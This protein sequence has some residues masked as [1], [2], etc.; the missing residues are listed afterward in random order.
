MTIRPA[1]ST[2]WQALQ[3]LNDEVITD[4]AQYDDDIVLGWALSDEGKEY[5]Q[6]IVQDPD[7]VCFVAEDEHGQLLGYIDA[8]PK[9]FGYRKSRYLEIGDMGVK[10]EYRSQGIGSMLMKAVQD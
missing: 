8:S 3:K 1:S 2:E 10:P 9:N 6:K 5:F 4:N 7:N